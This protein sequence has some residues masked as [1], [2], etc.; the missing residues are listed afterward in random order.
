MTNTQ[1]GSV[2]RT[3][4]IV[5]LAVGVLLTAAVMLLPKGFSDNLTRIGQGS[6]VAVLI[7]DK[8]TMGSMDFMALI[9]EVRS[10]YAG[11]IE[12]L[13]VDMAT[14]EGQI[15]TRKQGA[16]S[17]DLVLFGPDGAKRG[18]VGVGISEKELRSTLDALLPP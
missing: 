15:F 12:F 16:G 14:R 3:S 10:D 11:E 1:T 17:A 2:T 4:L 18:V 8:N 5:V 13:A 6:V 9:N 7:H